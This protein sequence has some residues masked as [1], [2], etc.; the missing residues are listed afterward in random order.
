M[1]DVK[2]AYI[3][4]LYSYIQF[5]LNYVGCKVKRQI[6]FLPDRRRFTLTMWDVKLYELADE[7]I[8]EY[9]FYLNYVG[10]KVDKNG[11]KNVIARVL[12]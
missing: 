11:N 7:A 12:P 2:N 1:W 4:R 5:Y 6:F 9:L 8:N 10:C 3:T